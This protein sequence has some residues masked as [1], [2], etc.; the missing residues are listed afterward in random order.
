LAAPLFAAEREPGVAFAVAIESHDVDAIKAL[1]AAGN[2]TETPIVYGEHSITPLLKAAWDGDQDIVATLLAAGAKVNAK[3]TD[4]LE[5]PLINAVSREHTEI[6]KMLIKAGADVTPKNKF[7]FNAFT[8]AVAAGKQE[9]AGL[10]LD[11]GAKVE[12]GSSGL[13]PLQ[14]A[15]SAGNV[16]MIRFLVK[17][18]ASV[19]HGAKAGEQTALLSAIYGAHPEAVQALIELKANL[20][21]STKD[22]TTPLKAAMKGDQDDIVKILK[23][24]GAKK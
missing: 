24:A 2:S 7:N 15:A 10:L 3:A 8:T 19:N 6:V 16:D 1:L 14:F 21:T 23:A 12:E 17:R 18:G 9:I 5:T 11:A 20:N 13:T 22:G 4:T